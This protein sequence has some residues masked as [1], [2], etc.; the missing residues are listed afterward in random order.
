MH[1]SR[2]LLIT[3]AIFVGFLVIGM[4]VLPLH[5][6]E[7]L[8]LDTSVVGLVAG[9][10]FAAAILSRIWAPPIRYARA[11]ARDDRAAS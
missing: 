7:G 1:R 11:E 3:G 10:Q 4:P 8:R 6:H 2:C 9:S 5:V